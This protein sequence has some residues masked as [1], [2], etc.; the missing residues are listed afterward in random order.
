MLNPTFLDAVEPL[1][2]PKMGTERM[3]PLLHSLIRFTKPQRVLE[4]GA[5][6]S[7]AFIAAALAENHRENLAIY[8]HT[9]GRK[10][11]GTGPHPFALPPYFAHPQAPKLHTIDSMAH[12]Y[13][14]A[15]GVLQIMQ[16]LGVDTFATVHQ[17]DF[18]G[19]SRSLDGSAL[20]LDLVWLDCGGLQNYTAFMGEYWDLINPDGGM[21]LVHST[22]TNVEGFAFLN[23]MKLR[24]AT[25]EFQ[26]FEMMSLLE[27]D[28]LMQNSV[29]LIRKTGGND[30]LY[31]MSP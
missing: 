17:G 1:R 28:K 14:T 30:R 11:D 19:F 31:S 25:A 16:T 8:D 4:I 22:L 6:Y 13:T 24:Q 27:P 15:G 23:K 2:E 9:S 10:M 20:P 7:T 12:S 21:L 26:D 29:T 5:G 18:K 3:A